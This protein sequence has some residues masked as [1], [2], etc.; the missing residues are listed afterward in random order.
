M[1]QKKPS[2]FKD[3]TFREKVEHIWE[4]YRIHIFVIIFV[5]FFVGSMLNHLVFNP[6]KEAGVF[7]GFIGKYMDMEQAKVVQERLTEEIIQDPTNKTEAKLDLFMINP[8]SKELMEV[9]M[10]NAQKLMAMLASKEIDILIA[11]SASFG[12]YVKQQAFLPLTEVFTEEELKQWEENCL[13]GKSEEDTKAQIYG[14]YLWDHPLLQ[15][16]HFTAEKPVIG[17][18][19]NTTRLEKAKETLRWFVK[20]GK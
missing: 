6:P 8:D 5:L 1:K 15:E 16:L 3:M 9:N 18:V 11:D 7:I 10:A 4:Y 17:I 19:A 20:Q 12:V 2:P 14:I 13:T